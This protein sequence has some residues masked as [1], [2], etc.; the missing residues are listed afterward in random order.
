VPSTSSSQSQTPALI[1]ETKLL[2]QEIDELKEKAARY[3]QQYESECKQR[4]EDRVA[5]DA[6]RKRWEEDG[7]TWNAERKR[8]DMQCALWQSHSAEW[9]EE[10]RW[11]KQLIDR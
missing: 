6:E 11:F 5:W 2:R 10:R 8:W 3:L 7:A 4:K 9:A 1:A